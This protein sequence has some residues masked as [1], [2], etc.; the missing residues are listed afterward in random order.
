MMATSAAIWT[1][2]HRR[3]TQYGSF[4]KVRRLR[5]GHM[6]TLHSTY[7]KSFSVHVKNTCQAPNV[8]SNQLDQYIFTALIALMLAGGTS[9][10]NSNFDREKSRSRSLSNSVA[11]CDAKNQ[12]TS[13]WNSP[14]IVKDFRSKS[15]QP[16]NVMLHRMRSSRARN[17]EEKYDIAWD[18]KLGE[19]AYGSVYPGRLSAT[20]EKV[21]RFKENLLFYVLLL[22]TYS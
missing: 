3:F 7:A 14:E 17:L 9:I 6:A 16:R 1:L 18:T 4:N 15:A 19:G 20:G 12:T 5:F 22:I 11:H 2:F 13:Q 21:S 8:A 10:A